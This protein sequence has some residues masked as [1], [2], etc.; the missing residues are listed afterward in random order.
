MPR[1]GTWNLAFSSYW[2]WIYDYSFQTFPNVSLE[3][4]LGAEGFLV[5]IIFDKQFPYSEM[6][7]AYVGSLCTDQWSE[8]DKRAK[9]K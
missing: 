1:E 4:D 7:I 9:L 6:C 3:Y 2:N 8:P 5:S